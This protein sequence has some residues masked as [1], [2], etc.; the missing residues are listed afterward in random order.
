MWWATAALAGP[1]A[2]AGD[3]PSPIALLSD[4]ELAEGGALFRIHCARCHGMQG[5]GGEGPSLKRPRLRHAPDDQALFDVISEGIPGTGMAGVWSPSEAERWRIAG[6]VRALGALPVESVPG[7]PVRGAELSRGSGGCPA[8]HIAGGEGRGVGPEL[9]DVGLRRNSAYLRAALLDPDAD[10][11]M[12]W[13]PIG[14]RQNAFLTVRLTAAEGE[15]E[16]LRISEDE[17]SIQLR[18]RGG[19]I[20]SFDKSRLQTFEKA[21]GHSLMP[22][23]QTTLNE[24]DVEDMVS[25]LMSLRGLP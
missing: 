14:G 16:G 24:Q 12:R 21:F 2:G 20:R 11:P 5:D 18:D 1:E 7:D 19:A 10:F 22:G 17:F 15:F 13:D 3:G 9:S 4:A 6:Y 25:Y 23:Y 8:C